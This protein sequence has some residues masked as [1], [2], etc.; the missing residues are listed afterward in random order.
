MWDVQAGE[1]RSLQMGQEGRQ[2]TFL[3]LSFPMGLCYTTGEAELKVY[4]VDFFS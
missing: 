3:V 4:E 2:A 1:S